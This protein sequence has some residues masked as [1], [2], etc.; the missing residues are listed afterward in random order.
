LPLR[1]RVVLRRKL[2]ER[3]RLEQRHPVGAR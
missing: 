1:H 3:R 2:R